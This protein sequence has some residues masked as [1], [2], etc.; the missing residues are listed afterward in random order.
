[1]RIGN[2]RAISDAYGGRSFSERTVDGGR[3]LRHSA[4]EIDL[5]RWRV[6]VSSRVVPVTPLQFRVLAHLMKRPGRV[7]TRSELLDA[8][9]DDALDDR[10]LESVDV[11]VSRLRAKLGPHGRSITT[12]RGVGYALGG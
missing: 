6:S 12:V 1:M 2:E 5:D 11:V 10:R 7:F 4:I 9:W 8:A 3:V